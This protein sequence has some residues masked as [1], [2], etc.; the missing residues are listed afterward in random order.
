L[1][2]GKWPQPRC[3]G[4]SEGKS[5]GLFD[6][7]AWHKVFFA[8]WSLPPDSGGRRSAIFVLP[9]EGPMAIEEEHRF[10]GAVADLIFDP[11]SNMLHAFGDTNDR[12]VSVKLP[13][14]RRHTDTIA[15]MFPGQVHYD[16]ERDEGVVCSWMTG[17][18]IRADPLTFRFFCE[19]TPSLWSCLALSWGCDWDPVQ[20]RVYSAVPN[21]G[22]LYTVNYDNGN[23]L[24]K[25]WVGFGM[26]SVTLDPQRQTL[27]LT[28]FLG[29]DIVA[30][31][32]RSGEE[33]RRWFVGRFPRD[34]YLSRDG[35]SLF[36]GTNLG[37]MR[38]DLQ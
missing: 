31:D 21:L 12:I 8:A 27:Y 17:A 38:I 18:K 3:L 6:A 9:A 16:A 25:K 26:R 28:D 10:E 33:Q 29:G 20:R 32:V 22:L 14:F 35:S 36:V 24:R 13:E 34:A 11:K 15:P 1:N 5:H 7:A 2:S 23:V 37:V 19:M 4:G 30:I